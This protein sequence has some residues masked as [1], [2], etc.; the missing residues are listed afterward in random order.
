MGGANI[1]PPRPDRVN[2]RQSFLLCC[3][4][5]FGRIENQGGGVKGNY[6][7]NKK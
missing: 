4:Q 5:R 2:R 7:E 1:P 3:F 6:Y